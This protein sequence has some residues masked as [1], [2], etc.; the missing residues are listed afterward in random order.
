MPGAPPVP[1][2]DDAPVAPSRGLIQLGQP[3]E[4]PDNVIRFPIIVLFPALLHP[5]GPPCPIVI[6]MIS[7]GVI[8]KG[9]FIIYCP[10]LPPV[11]PLPHAPPPEP[12]PA[13]AVTKI[14]FTPDGTVNCPLLRKIAGLGIDGELLTGGALGTG[15]E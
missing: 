11:P 5:D 14:V 6:L 7:P 13:I 12:P 2:G 4:P 3:P 1:K 10:A 8:E 15:A 9:W